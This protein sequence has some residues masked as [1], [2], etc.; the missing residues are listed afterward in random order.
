MDASQR[1]R[2]LRSLKECVIVAPAG[3]GK[4]VSLADRAR[5][6][7]HGPGLVRPYRYGG[8]ALPIRNLALPQADDPAVLRMHFL[9]DL[10]ERASR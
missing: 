4:R 2:L 7:K 5:V 6:I 8:I 1:N 9:E 10:L 3:R